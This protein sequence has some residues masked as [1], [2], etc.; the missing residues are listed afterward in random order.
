MNDR[1]EMDK[2]ERFADALARQ[3]ARRIAEAMEATEAAAGALHPLA[4]YRHANR[5]PDAPVD[6]AVERALRTDPAL[7]RRYRAILSSAALAVSPMAR[8]ASTEGETRRKIG[9]YDLRLFRGDEEQPAILIIETERRDLELP[10]LIDALGDDG[11]QRRPVPKGRD[12]AA[13]ILLSET[14]DADR[15]F[16]ALIASPTSFIALL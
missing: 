4:L 13:Q 15:Q 14:A 9:D 3:T 2:E 8:A 11:S 12:G 5:A 7:M 16:I 1:P 10:L 6:F